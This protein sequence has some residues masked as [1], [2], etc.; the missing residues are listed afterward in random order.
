MPGLRRRCDT[1]PLWIAL[2][3]PWLTCPSTRTTCWWLC[4]DPSWVNSMR[5]TWLRAR[6]C[7]FFFQ[8][9]DGIRDYKVTGV[10][11]CALPILTGAI[12]FN[13]QPTVT[14]QSGVP[15]PF[16]STITPI[17]LPEPFTI[18]GQLLFASGDT[19]KVAANTPV[20]IQRFQNDLAALTPGNQVQPLTTSAISREFRNGYIGTWTAALDRDFHIFKFSTS[21]VGTS[22]V[23]LQAV[24][25]S[26]GYSG[27]SPGFA[28]FTEIYAAGP[29]TRRLRF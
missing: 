1:L 29:G 10:Q 22:G 12:P 9:E 11:T 16:S 27:A 28:P 19:S 8:A 18:S 6:M 24:M 25:F 23:H 2:P 14:A 17:T 21:Y 20:D 4:A 15:V 5:S 13:V 7:F 3:Q 26:N